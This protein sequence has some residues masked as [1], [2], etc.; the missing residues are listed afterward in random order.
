MEGM[1]I[2]GLMEIKIVKMMKKIFE[3]KMMVNMKKE[4]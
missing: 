1:V 3:E 4:I 2:E